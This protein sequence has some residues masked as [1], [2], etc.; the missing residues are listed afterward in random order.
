MLRKRETA[1]A[2]SAADRVWRNRGIDEPVFFRFACH[3]RPRT[4]DEGIGAIIPEV[5]ADAAPT[6]ALLE[7][8]KKARRDR[9]A[10]SPL[11]LGDLILQAKGQS[12]GVGACRPAEVA[13][14]RGGGISDRADRR[15]ARFA[16]FRPVCAKSV[17]GEVAVKGT[18]SPRWD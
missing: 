3:I 17:S 6:G 11:P 1:R 9:P 14:D 15:Q 16:F 8:T 18:S 2:F 7:K 13:G 4:V 5:N 10:I 12:A